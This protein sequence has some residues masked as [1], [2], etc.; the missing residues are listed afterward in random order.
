MC[1]I[2]NISCLGN[3]KNED[4][5]GRDPLSATSA[6][7][8]NCM[9][10]LGTGVRGFLLGAG[11]GMG[12]GEGKAKSCRLRKQGWKKRQE[13]SAPWLSTVSASS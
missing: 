1:S 12:V 11:V 6:D 7:M 8:V 2:I 9:C 10:L 3:Y 13:V 5:R 4:Q